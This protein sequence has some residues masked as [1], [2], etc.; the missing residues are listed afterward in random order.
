MNII[1]AG[2]I[3]RHPYGGMAWCSLNYLLG[4]QRLGHRVWYLEDTGECNYD[5]EQNT[6]SKDP[7]YALDFIRRCLEPFGLADRWC[8]IDYRGGYYGKTR[9][10]WRRICA[11]AD[12]FLDL[13]GGC[14]FWRDEYLSIPRSA[15]I[16]SDPAFTQLNIAEHVSERGPDWHN[17]SLTYAGYF[18]QFDTLF[19]FGHNIGT[20]ACP[21]PTSSLHWQPTWQ[22]VCVDEW[23]PTPELPRPY[24]T[25]VMSWK[26]EDFVDIGGGKDLEFRKILDL[27]SSTD[28]PLELAVNA[29]SEQL[30]PVKE[31]LR[32][33][34]WRCQDAFSVSYDL[35]AYRQ[36][37]S[38]SLGEFGAAK[39]TY[40]H[41]KTGS[42]SD[43]T[44]CYLASGR[45]AVV[46]DIGFSAHLPT[47]EGLFAYRTA[48]EAIEGLE[49]VLA[50]YKRHSR[51]ARD[52]A[53]TYFDARRVLSDLLERIP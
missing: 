21:V 32:R 13:S 22:P 19:T 23:R 43:R 30:E 35:N 4:L 18:K 51:A 9:D 3:G 29:P 14:W 47:G 7:R 24:F 26:F 15:F 52:L 53:V 44:E 10:A 39:H 49:E 11:E 25:T 16:D 46:Q 41:Y 2:I 48:E 17:D 31:L 38:S 8:Y 6:I 12:L 1:F 50:D 40:V 33:H 42:L 5:P 27:P 45:P 36:Y 34:G 20:P 37:L 28:A